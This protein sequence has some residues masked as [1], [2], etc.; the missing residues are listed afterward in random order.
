M[1]HFNNNIFNNITLIHV[2]FNNIVF[3]NY[4]Y[5]KCKK[6][7]HTHIYIHI[8][9]LDLFSYDCGYPLVNKLLL[10]IGHTN[11]TCIALIRGFSNSI[12]R[13]VLFLAGR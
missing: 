6:F 8:I 1:A 10:Q 11:K 3:S 5:F 9:L 2:I 13:D 12:F 7:T 4:R